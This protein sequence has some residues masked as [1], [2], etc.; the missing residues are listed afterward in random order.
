MRILKTIAFLA[1]FLVPL[2][3]QAGEKGKVQG[4]IDAARAA[5]DAFAKKAD[6]NKLVTGDIEAARNALKK[7]EEAFAAGGT[8][9]GLGDISPE[10]TQD[11]K[12]SAD[13]T[14]L[15]LALAQSRLDNAKAADELAAMKVQVGKMRAK[16]KVFD[17]RKAE[18]ESLRASLAKFDATVKEL[19]DAK[20]ENSRCCAARERN[21]TTF[22]IFIAR[23]P[24]SR[25]TPVRHSSAKFTAS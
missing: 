22:A 12:F 9:F 1:L 23:S 7:G 14:D 6:G 19:G 4:Q 16:V 5:I 20:A 2:A 25:F 15:F 24:L 17:D 18:L 3:A 10:A 11:V 13:M 8:M 21:Y